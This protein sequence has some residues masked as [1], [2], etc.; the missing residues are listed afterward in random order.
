MLKHICQKGLENRMMMRMKTESS[1]EDSDKNVGYTLENVV[2]SG[3]DIL[4]GD[5][6]ISQPIPAGNENLSPA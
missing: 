4:L 1:N 6:D 5:T 2:S 3:G